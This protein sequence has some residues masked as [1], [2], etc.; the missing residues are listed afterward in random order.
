MVIGGDFN[1]IVRLDERTGGNGPLSP[2]LLT[3]GD[4]INEMSLI[5]LGFR[6]KKYTWKGDVWRIHLSQEIGSH[7]M[8]CSS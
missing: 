3:F 6:G 5:D 8:L 1:T 2:D 7:P 4:W